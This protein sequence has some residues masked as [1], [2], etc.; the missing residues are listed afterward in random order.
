[1][2]EGDVEN[3]MGALSVK[4]VVV[5]MARGE[6]SDDDPV[7][8][9]LRPVDFVPDTKPVGALFREMKKVGSQIAM[10]VDEFGGIAGLVT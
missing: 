4:D 3:V 5:A 8:G 1:M 9:L 7:T 2:F 10:A 6:V